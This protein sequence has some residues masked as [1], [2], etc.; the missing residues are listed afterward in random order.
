[1]QTLFPKYLV[2]C[3]YLKNIDNPFE[4]KTKIKNP[5]SKKKI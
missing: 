4:I 1:M 5:L 2:L 3:R